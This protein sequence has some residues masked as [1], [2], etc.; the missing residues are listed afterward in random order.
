MGTLG[1][2]WV[3][4]YYIRPTDYFHEQNTI[5]PHYAEDKAVVEGDVTQD[6]LD[7][8]LRKDKIAAAGGGG[9]HSAATADVGS[10]KDGDK[11][12]ITSV[13]KEA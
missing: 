7:N 3:L 5:A 9:S 13:D 4:I 6:Q 10:A 11:V 2:A 8:E 1:Q 12:G